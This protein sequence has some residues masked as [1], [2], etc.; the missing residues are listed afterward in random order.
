MGGVRDVVER[1]I[2]RYTTG[3]PQAS[4]IGAERR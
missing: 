3:W 4:R 2:Q 1:F